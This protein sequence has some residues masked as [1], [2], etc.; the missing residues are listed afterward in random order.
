M[1]MPKWHEL[2]RPTLVVLNKTETAST[3]DLREAAIIEFSMTDDEQ[4]E[5]LES[6][7]LRLL[8]RIGWAVT[9][10][11]KAGFIERVA[12]KRGV[13]RI[14]DDGRAFL[15]KHD[16]AFDASDLMAESE[17]FR[18]WKEGYREARKQKLASD[19]GGASEPD[20]QTPAEAM[21]AAAEEAR[22]AL[23]DEVLAR[24]MEQDSDFF[25]YL[26]GKL[27][28]ALGYGDDVEV[29][30]RTGD[31]GI[32]GV[33]KEDRLG[34]DSIYYQAKRWDLDTSVSRPEVQKF[35]GA[36]SGK[37]AGKGLFITTARFSSGAREF[38]E[39][40]NAAKIVLVD[41]S[42]LARLMIDAGVGV[43]TVATYEVKAIDTD[44]FEG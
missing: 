3:A 6:G 13:Y 26:V 38:A 17:A 34:F 36:L 20:E 42:A 35:A 12:G 2:M 32:D 30:Q 1:T 41:G 33:V 28:A 22:D 21:A 37:S 25:E 24:I 4:Q 44:F 27:L 19:D 7:Q 39:K 40:Q 15:G 5:R 8:N 43:S 31:E 23:A 18:K 16:E 11:N 10:L 29:T 9:D 14:T